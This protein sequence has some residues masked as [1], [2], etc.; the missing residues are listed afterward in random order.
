MYFT[1]FAYSSLLT[2]ALGFLAVV[3]GVDFFV[4]ALLIQ[5]DLAMFKSMPGTWIP[6]CVILV[7]T[8]I[9]GSVTQ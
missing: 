7:V 8:Y 2:T 1:H 4:V 5:R 3:I 9:V 6:F